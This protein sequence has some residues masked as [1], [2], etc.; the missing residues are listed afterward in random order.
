MSTRRDLWYETKH[1]FASPTTARCDEA[2]AHPARES[3]RRVSRRRAERE[4]AWFRPV[5]AAAA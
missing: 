1:G 4:R 5:I 2:D 3:H